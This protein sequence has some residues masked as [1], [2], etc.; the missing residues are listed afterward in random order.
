MGLPAAVLLKEQSMNIIVRG[1]GV[2]LVALSA[3]MTSVTPALA[4][5]KVDMAIFHP[6]RSV[7]TPTLKW[8]VAEVEK[9][10]QGRVKFAPQYAG[11]LVTLNETLR[12]V[13]D[14]AVP[15]GVIA[16]GAISGQLPYVSYL[17]AIGGLPTDSAKFAEAM[18][19]IH[20]ILETEFRKQNVEYLWGQGSGVL[21][22][23][24]RDR[25]IKTAAEWKS[26]KV[27]TGG[28]WQAEQM[29][30]IGAS[31]VAMDPSEQYVA[32]QNR[33]IDCVLS[34]SPIA[35]ALKLHEVGPKVTV[36]RL[37]V[38]LSFYVMNKDLYA[39]LSAA[40]RAAI[41]RVSAEADKRSIEYLAKADNEAIESMKAGKADL[42]ALTD[43][44]MADFRKAISPSF[45]K[46]DAEGGP[47]G[48]QISDVLKRFH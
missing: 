28:R 21:I 35:A 38:N 40:D 16:A 25:H 48:K 10:T 1:C 36:L 27:R 5:A 3:L 9:V 46:M 12:S 31:P 15:S 29:R 24:C 34:V 2:A 37:P 11:S 7:W 47:V 45:T 17:E 41:R 42:Y 39:K 18:T 26:R 32:M 4:Q 6:E 19:A 30:T 23:L 8:W 44:E 33:T 14:G 22:S 43:A 20:P 13:R